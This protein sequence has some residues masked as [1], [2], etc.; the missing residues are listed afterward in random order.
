MGVVLGVTVFCMVLG[1]SS[2]AGLVGPGKKLRWVALFVLAVL[3]VASV[4]RTRP[5]RPERRLAVV[6][7]LS[8]WL[9][10]IALVS[11][12]WSVDPHLTVGRAASFALLLVTACAL[13]YAAAGSSGLPARLLQGMLAGTVAAALVGLLLLAIAHTDAV[14]I[15][16]DVSPARFRGLGQN[17]DTMAMLE[18]ITLPVALWGLVR[19]RARGSQLLYLGAALLLL[20]SISASGSRGGL[21]AALVGGLAFSVALRGSWRRKTVLALTVVLASVGAAGG[22]KIPKPLSYAAPGTPGYSG[23]AGLARVGQAVGGPESSYGGRLSDELY[24]VQAGKRSLLTSSGRLQAWYTAIEQADARPFLG[25]GFGTEDKVFV[26]RVYN[27]D[28]SFVENSFIGFYLQL[29]IVGAVSAV[30]LLLALA[31]AAVVAV[32]RSDDGRELAPAL[33]AV[34]AAGL[35]LMLVQSYVYAVGNIA[36]VAFWVSGLVVV[37]IAHG[38]AARLAGAPD[39]GE[40]AVAAA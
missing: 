4:V 19:A 24:R 34:V 36:T 38:P 29:G 12:A 21:L 17:P 6:A 10:A 30:A 22:M 39:L 37:A 25:Y 40:G 27:F 28:G 33:A 15:A 2:V 1:S 26:D 9:T 8:A 7:A 13:A 20:A 14:Q 31:T 35:A 11:A 3:A 18:G 23:T 16:T 5:R 32:R